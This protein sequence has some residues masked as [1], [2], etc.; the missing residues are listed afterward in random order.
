MIARRALV[1][2]LLVPAMASAQ[3][4]RILCSGPSDRTCPPECRRDLSGSTTP[5]EPVDFPP[6]TGGMWFG[7]SM[8]GGA[9]PD[10]KR[11]ILVNKNWP[12]WRQKEALHHERCH[13]ELYRLTGSHKFHD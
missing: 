3:Q 11:A 13:D 6:T 9:N 7:P 2:L 8:F 4:P 12:G 5:V 1:V 10:L